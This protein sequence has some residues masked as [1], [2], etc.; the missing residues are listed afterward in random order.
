MMMQVSALMAGQPFVT[1]V[2]GLEGVIK[3]PLDDQPGIDRDDMAEA[4]S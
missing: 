1:C 2:S 3:W 4:R